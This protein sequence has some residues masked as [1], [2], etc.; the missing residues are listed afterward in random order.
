M[1]ST[2][3]FELNFKEY[4]I[5]SLFKILSVKNTNLGITASFLNEMEMETLKEYYTTVATLK[6]YYTA[7]AIVIKKICLPVL[8]IT[9]FIGNSITLIVLCKKRNRGSP[10]SIILLFL[11]LSDIFV[12]FTGYLTEWINI[13]WSVRIR[14]INNV[15]CKIHVLFTYFSLMFSSWLLVLITSVRAYSVV[16]PHKAKFVCNRRKT[17]AVIAITAILLLILNGHFLYGMTIV[18]D[19]KEQKK[20]YYIYDDGYIYFAN[21]PWV[22]IDVFVTFAIPFLLIA[23]G[24]ALIIFKMKRHEKKQQLMVAGQNSDCGPEQNANAITRLL[25]LLSLVFIICCGP[26]SVIYTMA[27]YHARDERHDIKLL[28]VVELAFLFSGLNATMNFFLY[29]LS[30]SKFR[31]DVKSLFCFR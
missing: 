24:N 28:F 6:E 11:S 22:W 20:C 25:I 13:L 1:N 8:C 2:F 9:G 7:L 3:E 12:L 23:A 15:I 26:W 14:A 31:E 21:R 17:L 16:S 29:I 30:G 19:E 5:I 18:T 10:M 4:I 27:Q